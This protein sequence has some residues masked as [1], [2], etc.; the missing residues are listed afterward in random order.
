MVLQRRKKRLAS[1]RGGFT[2]IELLVVIAIIAILAGL[3]LPAVQ[4]AREAARRSQCQNNMR[5][6]TIGAMG[7]E[8]TY[9]HFM[10]GWNTHGTL[11]SAAIL[12]HLEQGPIYDQLIFGESG[13][14]NWGATGSPNRD[15]AETQFPVFRCPSVP[16]SQHFNYN[17]IAERFA[18]SYR[19]VGASDVSSDDNSTR[20]ISGTK[21]F[22]A[23]E[24]N[25]V[26]YGC[27]TT[28]ISAIRDGTSNTFM[29][30]ESRTDPQFVKD[31]QGMD[32]WAIGS[33]QADPCRCTGSNNGTEFSEAVGSALPQLNVAVRNPATNGYLIEVAFGS[34][35]SGG[36]VFGMA[37]GSVH[38]IS[39]SIDLK[40]YQAMATR[41]G[42]ETPR[43]SGL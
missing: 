10:P 13:L 5:Q 17:G 37:D 38:F 9:R 21:S 16:V 22:E 4:Q 27:S 32:F 42:A 29:F 35:H 28:R 8:S 23:K 12:P 6:L 31:G 1:N 30:G 11:W 43:E 20:P 19:G 25:G 34:Y 2:I 24:L 39:D 15:A 26:F 33:P 40:T 7:Y 14:G 3:L 36:A 41:W 18:V